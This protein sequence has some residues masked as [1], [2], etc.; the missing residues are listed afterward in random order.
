[1]EKYPSETSNK[2]PDKIAETQPY[3][4]KRNGEYT[5][6]DYYALPD[7]RRVELIDGV[8]Y[9]MASPSSVHQIVAEE[10][11]LQFRLYV[12]EKGG[13][14]RPLISPL[15]VQLDCDDRTMVQPDVLIVCDPK[16]VIRR[17]VYGAPDFVVEV[18][19]EG[20][21]KKDMV[22][23]LGKY[24]NAGVREYWIVD[25]K[26]KR[27]LVYDFESGLPAAVYGITDKIPVGIYGGECM[28]DFGEV[29]EELGRGPEIKEEGPERV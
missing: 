26:G 5:L 22:L 25:M 17:C 18:L 11:F 21:R 19:S 8:F 16:K 10:I 15:D 27:V 28:I 2:Q 29:Q 6:E 24:R 20:T 4:V 9:D 3:R 23:K 13:K 7:E 14:C 12:K 1:M